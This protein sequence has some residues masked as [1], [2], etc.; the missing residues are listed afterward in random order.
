MSF[1]KLV[2]FNSTINGNAEIGAKKPASLD[3]E[4]EKHSSSRVGEVSPDVN[5]SE[6]E[7]EKHPEK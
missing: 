1:F 6:N 5:E 3:I 7:E 2:Q 4:P